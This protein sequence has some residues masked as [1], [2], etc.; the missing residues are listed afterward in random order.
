MFVGQTHTLTRAR[1]S[2]WTAVSMSIQPAVLG[3][4]D[5]HSDHLS[6]GEGQQG[7][8]GAT[9]LV[10]YPGPHE[11]SSTGTTTSHWLC[12]ANGSHERWGCRHE[13]WNTW[14][15]RGQFFKTHVSWWTC[16]NGKESFRGGK[17]EYKEEH[18]LIF[19]LLSI[20]ETPSLYLFLL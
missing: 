1:L 7:G 2:P 11:S 12:R 4:L 17:V 15:Q 18:N 8:I 9:R 14:M 3:L 16:L 10:G 13:K 5:Q 20:F 6:P 19:Y